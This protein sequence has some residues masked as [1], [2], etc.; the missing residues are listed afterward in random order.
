MGGSLVFASPSRHLALAHVC[1]QMDLAAMAVDP[2]TV[3]FFHPIENILHGK[4][5]S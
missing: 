2:R 1:N 4:M 5:S 3:R